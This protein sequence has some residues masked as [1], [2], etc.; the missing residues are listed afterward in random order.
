MSYALSPF[1]TNEAP[2]EPWLLVR[3][4]KIEDYDKGY[5]ELLSQLTSVGNI[6]RTQFESK[7]FYLY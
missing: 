2:G 1:I 6:T 7:Y 4:L 5:L 3:P